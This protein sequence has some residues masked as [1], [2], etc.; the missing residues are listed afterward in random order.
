MPRKFDLMDDIILKFK[1]GG[2]ADALECKTI[3][4]IQELLQQKEKKEGKV[5]SELISNAIEAEK[6]GKNRKSLIRWLYHA[7]KIGEIPG[8]YYIDYMSEVGIW[9]SALQKY[10]R[11]SEVG[12]AVKAAVKLNAM[13]PTSLVRRLKVILC[14]DCYTSI[15]LYGLID[16]NPILVAGYAADR[17]K[18]GHCCRAFNEIKNTKKY[19]D[20]YDID[21]I[22]DNW[23]TGDL[24]KVMSMIFA[25]EEDNKLPVLNKILTDYIDLLPTRAGRDVMNE[26]LTSSKVDYWITL[27]ALMRMLRNGYEIVAEKVDKSKYSDYMKEDLIQLEEVNWYALDMHTFPGR[28]ARDITAKKKGI[29]RNK[30]GWMWW[31]GETSIRVPENKP[32]EDFE[33]FHM[34]D[35]EKKGI[36]DWKEVRDDVIKTLREVVE[37]KF[38]ITIVF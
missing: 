6:K 25:L 17:A 5:S 1:G 33:E 21:W 16:T 10:I 2:I 38:K 35:K 31:F 29:S 28:V 15:D 30:L 19:K 23:K 4:E 3:P 8:E 27:V 7:K 9:K 11:R 34:T 13:Q 36:R 22:K 20:G 12:K 37:N 18:D 32:P 14:E 24:S 26:L